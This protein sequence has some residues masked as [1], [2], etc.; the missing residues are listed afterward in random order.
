L[1]RIE[2]DSGGAAPQL[3]D[4]AEYARLLADEVQ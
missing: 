3:L 4:A 1:I 2:I